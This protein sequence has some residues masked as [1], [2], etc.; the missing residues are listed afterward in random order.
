V[1]APKANVASVTCSTPPSFTSTYVYDVA[2]QMRSA[3]DPLGHQQQATY[4][5]NGNLD[6]STNENGA[7]MTFGYDQMDRITKEVEPFIGGLTPRTETTKY[8]YDPVGNLS[9]VISPRAYD[10]STDKVTFTD[11]V[12]TYHYNEARELSF[13]DLP[14]NASTPAAFIYRAYDLNGQMTNVTLPSTATTYAGVSTNDRTDLTLLDT[15]MVNTSNNHVDPIVH[16]RYDGRGNQIKRWVEKKGAPASEADPGREDSWEYY[17]NG[18]LHTVSDPT[19]KT[20]LGSGK[21]TFTYDLDNNLATADSSAGLGSA[22]ET[23]M[24][25]TAFYDSLDRTTKVNF[26]KTSEAAARSTTY[27]Y[28]LN[29]NV[30]TRVDNAVAGGAA[31]ETFTFAYDQ[32]DWLQSQIDDMGTPADTTDDQKVTTDFFATGWEKQRQILRNATAWNAKQTTVWDYFANGKLKTLTTTSGTSTGQVKENHTISYLDASNNYVNGNRTEDL[33]GIDGPSTP[34]QC[35]VAVKCNYKYTY[36]ARDR[37]TKFV[38]GHTT[39]NTTDYTLDPV[40]NITQTKLNGT[41]Q[42]NY[43]YQGARLN[44]VSNAAGAVQSRYIYDDFGNTDCIVNSTYAGSTCPMIGQSNPNVQRNYDY[45]GLNRL[46]AYEKYDGTSTGAVTD[47]AS[48][49]YD[50][51]NRLTKQSE[52]HAGN[53]R[54]TA[55]SFLGMTSAITKETVT[56]SSLT[57]SRTY[58]YDAY[59]DRISMTDTPS[60]AG[61]TPQTY[62][63][64]YDAHGS[65]SLLL[66][67]TGGAAASYAYDPYGNADAQVTK[68]TGSRPNN[69]PLNVFRYSAM[70]YDSGSDTLDMGAR[71][72]GP[73]SRFLQEDQYLGSLD[74]LSL[75][76][77]PINANRYS[78]AGGNPMSFIEWDGHYFIQEGGDG[79]AKQR[80]RPDNG[81]VSIPARSSRD[82]RASVEHEAPTQSPRHPIRQVRPCVHLDCGIEDFHDLTIGQRQTWLRR[83][84]RRVA[85]YL[86]ARGWF[87]SIHD[88]L[89]LAHERN[90]VEEKPFFS[91]VDATILHAIQNGARAASGDIENPGRPA[92]QWAAFFRSRLGGAPAEESVARWGTAEQSATVVG[93]RRAVAR[94]FD[95]SLQERLLLGLGSYWR[96]I[97]TDTDDEIMQ[98]GLSDRLFDPRLRGPLYRWATTLIR[99][100]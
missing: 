3:T 25:I 61:A 100:P 62:T 60:G 66:N 97:L 7:V 83:F 45:D 35:T 32:A 65:V 76:E 15:G 98:F 93:T 63:Y 12:T 23:P 74:D 14:T 69:D 50:A 47:S 82:R 2:H 38:D 75:T 94:G 9:K 88:V 92:I 30:T 44:T 33:F 17:P 96:G 37:V 41:V 72:F 48:Y 6:T 36:D 70:R 77:D 56:G 21:Q 59:G 13:V 16:Y 58:G 84:N 19:S 31:G 71:R 85:P 73:D 54:N 27:A 34:T 87:N 95:P 89:K 24:D 86:R 80:S 68:E 29:S 10:A 46:Q 79:G 22:D 4:D 99:E 1:T 67:G 20:V 78:L 91:E 39:S 53:T 18:L 64:G 26:Q 90:W 49:T 51:L 81:G 28:D 42:A 5:A 8:V 43:N 57:S 55:F 40:G 11:Y 52:K